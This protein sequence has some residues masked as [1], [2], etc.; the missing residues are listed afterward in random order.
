MS[1]PSDRS[2][3]KSEIV[4]GVLVIICAVAL[5][6]IFKAVNSTTDAAKLERKYP[7]KT[8]GTVVR[9]DKDPGKYVDKWGQT[10]ETTTIS[11]PIVEYTVDGKSYE[12]SS[13]GWGNSSEKLARVGLTVDVCYRPENP[14]DAVV[15]ENDKRA[16]GPL[17]WGVSAALAGLGILTC[18]IGLR[19]ILRENKSS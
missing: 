19:K 9:I 4:V 10:V 3:T 18:V 17:L 2:G 16:T 15:L 7:G 13:T 8:R 11:T 14:S 6:F 12:K 5:P 1:Y